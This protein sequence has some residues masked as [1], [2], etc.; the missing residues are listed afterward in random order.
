[1][2]ERTY[3]CIAGTILDAKLNRLFHAAKRSWTGRMNGEEKAKEADGLVAS[4]KRRNG[5]SSLQLNR[6]DFRRPAVVGAYD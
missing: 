5:P 1:V 6:S 3:F 2:F 4:S